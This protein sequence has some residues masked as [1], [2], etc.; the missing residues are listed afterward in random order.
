MPKKPKMTTD[1]RKESY[2]R[3][4]GRKELTPRQERRIRQKENQARGNK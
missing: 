4:S 1:D 3:Q 2:L